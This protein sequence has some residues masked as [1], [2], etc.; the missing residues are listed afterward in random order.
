[1]VQITGNSLLDVEFKNFPS[2][3]RNLLCIFEFDDKV[4]SKPITVRVSEI[5]DLNSD[6]SENDVISET[7]ILRFFLTVLNFPIFG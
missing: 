5:R 3:N 2:L 4:R 6:D 1:M 7:K